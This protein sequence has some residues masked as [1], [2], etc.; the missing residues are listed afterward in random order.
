MSELKATPGPWHV[1]RA[2]VDARPIVD[3]E[4]V[5]TIEDE[6]NRCVLY[7]EASWDISSPDAHLIAAA[8]SLYAAGEGL[9]VALRALRDKRPSEWDALLAGSAETT[10]LLDAWDAQKAALAKARGEDA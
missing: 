5:T 4:F 8:P 6:D 3:G 7:H 9:L 1:W 2:Q 10:D